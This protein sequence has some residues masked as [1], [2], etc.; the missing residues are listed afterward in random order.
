ML[1]CSVVDNRQGNRGFLVEPRPKVIATGR[2]R[3]YRAAMKAI[4]ILERQECGCWFSNRAENSRQ[5]FRRR[6]GAMARFM[7]IKARQK[8]ASAHAAIHKPFNHERHLI[9]RDIFKQIR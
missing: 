2:L 6:E 7:D 5:P 3:S 4:G 1:V 9:H 8:F